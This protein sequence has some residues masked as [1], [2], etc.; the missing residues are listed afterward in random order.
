MARLNPADAYHP[1]H[2]NRWNSK[3][4]LKD[5]RWVSK[6][7]VSGEGEP[8]MAGWAKND[9]IPESKECLFY[10]VILDGEE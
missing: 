1:W 9:R 7:Q 3:D 8:W 2:D 4:S 5:Y 6:P 10:A